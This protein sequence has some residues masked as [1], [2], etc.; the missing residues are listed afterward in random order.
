[1]DESILTGEST[2]VDKNTEMMQQ[3]TSASDCTNMAYAGTTVHSGRARGV[4]VT[5]G[6]DTEIG[7][8]ADAVYSSEEVKPPLLVRM[9]KFSKQIGLI[10]LG[11]SA[12]VAAVAIWQGYQY[13][14]VFLLAVALAVSAIPEGLP[15]AVT[16]ALS[17][18]TNR[19]AARNV[20]IRKLA[21][22]ES[23]GSC[24]LIASDKTGTLTVNRQT[25][26]RIT[27][28]EGKSYKV[29]G[30]G[31]NDEGSVTDNEDRE[32][33]SDKFIQEIAETCVM[34]NEASLQ[35]DNGD[36]EYSGDPMEIALL[37]FSYKA[38][39]NPKQVKYKATTLGEVPFES[40]TRFSAR[41]YKNEDK[42]KIAVKGAAEVVVPLCDKI[43][44]ENGRQKT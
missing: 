23:L 20:I 40:E 1:M 25:V 24:T 17:I 16:V 13:T 43:W 34:D 8:I 2:S 26:R 30:Q 28:G 37:A 22:V 44:S 39:L 36:W 19:M 10:V 14:E 27:T 21:A 32:V 4:V 33:E 42:H 7:K 9:D 31:Y 29:S 5:T 6:L 12:V 35:K 38:G 41:F 3:E 15:I 18:S 11:A